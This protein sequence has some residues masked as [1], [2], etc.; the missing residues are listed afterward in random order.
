MFIIFSKTPFS[1]RGKY[2]VIFTPNIQ[3]AHQ[4]KKKKKQYSIPL[5]TKKFKT[6]NQTKIMTRNKTGDF[7]K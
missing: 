5:S 2:F 7:N 3:S 4:K 6:H 1:L